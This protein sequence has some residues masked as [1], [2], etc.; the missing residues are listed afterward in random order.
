MFMHHVWEEPTDNYSILEDSQGNSALLFLTIPN[1]DLTSV[2]MDVFISIT[3]LFHSHSQITPC[4]P[5]SLY[6]CEYYSAMLAERN[7]A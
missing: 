4:T 6:N 2:A 3:Y 5:F 7:L 1:K